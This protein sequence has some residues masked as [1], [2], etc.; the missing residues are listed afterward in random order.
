[1]KQLNNQTSP[2]KLSEITL[3]IEILD[4]RPHC[5]NCDQKAAYFCFEGRCQ[6]HNKDFSHFCKQEQFLKCLDCINECKL[7]NHITVQIDLATEEF[8]FEIDELKVKITQKEKEI[9][10]TIEQSIQNQVKINEEINH[11]KTFIDQQ[12]VLL[13]QSIDLFVHN[14]T[15]TLQ[16]KK[17][18]LHSK[19]EKRI[20]KERKRKKELKKEKN[21]LRTMRKKMYYHHQNQQKKPKKRKTK[22]KN[23]QQEEQE[24][25]QKKEQEKEQNKHD[26]N[27][28]TTQNFDQKEQQESGSLLLAKRNGKR[29]RQKRI[30]ETQKK[31]NLEIIY[32]YRELKKRLSLNNFK[33]Q[34]EELQII[35][36]NPKYP[37]SKEIFDEKNKDHSI[38]LL[39]NNRTAINVSRNYI[40]LVCGKQIY[41]KGIHEIKIKI[42]NFNFSRNQD[43]WI[44]LGVVNSKNRRNFIK[45]HEWIGTYYLVTEWNPFN[46]ERSIYS[47]KRKFDPNKISQQYAN[48]FTR[49]DEIKILLN[50]TKREISF[51]INNRDFGVAWENLPKSVNF[52]VYL[53]HQRRNDRNQISLCW[54]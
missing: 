10:R 11:L 50:M 12:S 23:E 20:K 32:E 37:I 36:K 26:K 21:N 6:R 46:V 48:S 17:E 13:K 44:C 7:K 43:N 5:R 35:T 9:D 15:Q 8:L 3:P 40:G 33:K 34:F 2:L 29:K 52:F 22:N 24:Q 42:D 47:W 4:K 51:S 30:H 31:Q 28:N 25:E 27:K 1:M 39:N 19:F 14:S 18:F 41:S 38:L 53:E 54:D 16:N 45:N 49:G